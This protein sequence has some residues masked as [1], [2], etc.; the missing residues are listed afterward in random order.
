MGDLANRFVAVTVAPAS[1]QASQ[2]LDLISCR[3]S[4]WRSW[5]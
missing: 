1:G 5:S 2:L 3:L 4:A